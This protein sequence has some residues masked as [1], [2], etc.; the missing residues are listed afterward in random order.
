[1]KTFISAGIGDAFCMDTILTNEE[2]E[3]ITEIYW[4][5]KYGKVL[6]PIFSTNPLYPNLKKQY[7]L[8]VNDVT[9]YFNKN[10]PPNYHHHG[11]PNVCKFWHFKNDPSDRNHVDSYQIACNIFNIQSSDIQQDFSPGRFFVDGNRPY[12]KST[13]LETS[14]ETDFN[15]SDYNIKP[16]NYILVHHSSDNRPKTDIS[17]IND[18]DWSIME[19][20]SVKFN[21][22]VV[23]IT[24]INDINPPLSNYVVIN[25]FNLPI[26]Y[27]LKML[28]CLCKYSHSYIGLDSYIGILCS[29]ILPKENLYIK[30]HNSGITNQLTTSTWLQKFFLP[31]SVEDIQKFY[32]YQK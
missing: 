31:H 10:Y 26:Q 16:N 9:E 12:N 17:S 21:I 22:P 25:V 13:F 5:C 7:T 3:S 23:I 28:V 14:K 1:M 4:A 24:D 2:R 29:K 6:E 20:D 15:W 11:N 32:I 19:E 27:S 30:S 18:R 8:D